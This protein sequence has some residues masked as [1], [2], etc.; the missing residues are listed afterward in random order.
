MP[1]DNDLRDPN[2]GELH[3]GI[4]DLIV[5]NESRL[6]LLRGKRAAWEDVHSVIIAIK[7]ELILDALAGLISPDRE[8][9]AASFEIEF[10]V[11][12]SRYLDSLFPLTPE[13]PEGEQ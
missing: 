8:M 13:M 3:K 4:G 5:H 10:Q 9:Q 12:L 11:G 1:V 2:L 6:T 7:L